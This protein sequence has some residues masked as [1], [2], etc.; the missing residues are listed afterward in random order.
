[1]AARETDV[2]FDNAQYSKSSVGALLQLPYI[3]LPKLGSP[4]LSWQFS[5]SMLAEMDE[6]R[7]GQ[8]VRCVPTLARVTQRLQGPLLPHFIRVLCCVSLRKNLFNDLIDGWVLH[9]EIR[10]G[11]IGQQP[12]GD[13]G[14]RH[15]GHP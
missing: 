3:N 13:V 12:A 4:W 5:G 11:E 2:G 7:A 1:M 6:C 9:R 8:N 14:R 15:F 10:N